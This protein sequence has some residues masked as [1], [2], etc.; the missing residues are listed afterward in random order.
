MHIAR[1]REELRAT[2]DGRTVLV[3][4]MGALHAGHAELIR[5]AREQAGEAGR[6]VVSIFVN[7]TQFNEATDFERYPRELE[8][9]CEKCRGLGVD[10]V[11]A[12]T[13]EV[14]YPPGEEVPAGDLPAVATEPGLEDAHRPGHFAGVCQV[15]RRLFVLVEPAAAVFGEK[16]WQQLQTIRA[17]TEADGLGVE[18]V[19]APTIREPD[20]LA[21]SSRNLLLSPEAR[22]AAG[23]T[24]RALEAAGGAASPVAA[25]VVMMGVLARAGLEAEYAVVRD[26]ATLGEFREGEPGRALIAVRV[27][28][29]RLIDNAPWP[30]AEGG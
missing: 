4:T 29:V 8:A 16:D 24:P 1:S 12:P 2:P 30:G 21:M 14:M 3:P 5:L 23:A 11:F 17:M 13:P 10:V 20:G 19:A 25:G 28:D 7:P 27:G 26:A 15:V 22:D 9:D 6:V 18:I